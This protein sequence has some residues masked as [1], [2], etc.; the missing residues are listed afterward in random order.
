M[1]GSTRHNTSVSSDGA[2]SPLI[3]VENN[4]S[5]WYYI[6]S[7]V[8]S[9]S[10]SYSILMES[11]G[12]ST[13]YL[14]SNKMTSKTMAG[15]VNASGTNSDG[16]SGTSSGFGSLAW[17]AGSTP[18]WN[19]CYW[20]WN[21]TLSG[22]SNTNKAS[23]SDV[24]SAINTADSDFYSWLNGLGALDQDGRGKTRGSTTWPGAYDAT[25]N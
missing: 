10:S 18:A 24:K 20:S 6:N 13:T 22:G 8:A 19:N 11:S 25:N 4:S 12:S 9:S 2:S 5:T 7:I 14:I 15:T 16:F 3:R 17:T 1:I 21:G 23:L